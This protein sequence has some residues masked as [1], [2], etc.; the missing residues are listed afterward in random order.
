MMKFRSLFTSAL[1]VATL[2][3]CSL[4]NQEE[5]KNPFEGVKAKPLYDQAQQALSKGEYDSA[6]KRFE[7]LDAMYPFSKY[8]EPADLSLIYAY[9]QNEEYPSAAAAAERY[10][11]L[12]PSAAHV[13]YA[14]YMR[15]LANFQQNRVILAKV[16]PLN[17]SW[18][19]PGTQFESYTNFGELLQRYPHSYYYNNALQRMVYLRNMF[20]QHEW[21]IAN[22][23]FDRK[24]YVAAAE[25]AQYLI[26]NY[27]QAP[28][29]QYALILLYK[30]DKALGL[31]SA[32]Q[33]IQSVY[34][35]TYH[36]DITTASIPSTIE[37]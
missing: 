26:K 4:F 6:A 20:A 31:A 34:A 28:V 13:D 23:Y 35:A 37:W 33:D 24:R 25:R 17:E 21:N 7:A 22:Y 36:Q 10:I 5:D 11:H 19:D 14:Y 3:S 1:L 12:Y 2:S 8:A 32:M 30:S 9:Y 29:V 16:L 18:R 27:P 15:G